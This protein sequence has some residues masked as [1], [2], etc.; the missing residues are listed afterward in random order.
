MAID[1]IPMINVR[2]R[3]LATGDNPVIR[4]FVAVIHPSER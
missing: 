2:Y 4:K 1:R 3:P